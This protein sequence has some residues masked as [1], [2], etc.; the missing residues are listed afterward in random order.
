M[1][2]AFYLLA[3]LALIGRPATAS[4]EHLLSLQYGRHSYTDDVEQSVLGAEYAYKFRSAL[5]FGLG[6]DYL[7][8]DFGGDKTTSAARASAGP[9]VHF[10]FGC[11]P[12]DV[13]PGIGLEYLRLRGDAFD[14]DDAFGAYARVRVMLRFMNE[15]SVGMSARKSWNAVDSFGQE[16]VGVVQFRFDTEQQERRP[17]PKKPPERDPGYIEYRY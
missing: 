4:A 7:S 10:I 13:V 8:G 11:F 3:A 15:I 12:I 2:P 14:R 5:S 17:P 9:N 6:G 16:V 1:R